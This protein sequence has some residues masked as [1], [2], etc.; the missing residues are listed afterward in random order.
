MN[1]DITY[2]QYGPG[3]EENFFNIAR[4]KLVPITNN[5]CEIAKIKLLLK[6]K[7]NTGNDPVLSM[8]HIPRSHLRYRWNFFQPFEVIER[9]NLLPH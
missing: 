6:V 9:S 4:I 3:V 7:D 2:L 8:A 1:A 5:S